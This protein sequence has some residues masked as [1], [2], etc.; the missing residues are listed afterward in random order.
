MRLQ[1]TA[2]MKTYPPFAS[3]R[4]ECPC[5][6]DALFAPEIAEFAGERIRHTWFCDSCDHA[7]RTCVEIRT[8]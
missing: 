8:Q 5:C 1:T 6:G 2:P 4:P 7:F 3:R